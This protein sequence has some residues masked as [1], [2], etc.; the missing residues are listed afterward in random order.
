[1]TTSFK[2]YRDKLLTDPRVQKAYEALDDEYALARAIIQA[3]VQSGLTQEELA[4]RMG[5][6][7]SVVARLESGK[8]LPSIRT[9]RRVAEATGT[10]LRTQ[11]V[12]R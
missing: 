2:A 5:T 12:E 1:M 9:L 7:Q 4:K 11:F 3:R 8:R 10:R 6:T